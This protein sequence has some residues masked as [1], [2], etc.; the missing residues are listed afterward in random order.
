V[1]FEH[2]APERRVVLAW[3]KSFTRPEAISAL[4]TSIEQLQ[5]PGVIA[6]K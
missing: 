1:P 2:P 3:R 5:L 6:L 4:K